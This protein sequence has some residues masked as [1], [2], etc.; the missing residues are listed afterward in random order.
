M[1]GL[2]F[3]FLH[4]ERGVKAPLTHKQWFAA[5]PR[6]GKLSYL[7][8]AIPAWLVIGFNSVT[9]D[10]QAASS[11]VAFCVFA[12]V[13]IALIVEERRRKKTEDHG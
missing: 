4:R 10:P 9:G 13:A 8:L 11:I 1:S 5:L 12:A 2:D 7:L 6:W 3:E